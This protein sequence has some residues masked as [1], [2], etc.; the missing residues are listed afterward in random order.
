MLQYQYGSV[1]AQAKPACW[2]RSYE[3]GNRECR[4]C[5]FQGS[6]K[7]E[8]IRAAVNRPQMYQPP[9]YPQYQQ[10]QPPI[11]VPQVQVPQYQPPQPTFARSLTNWQPQPQPQPQVMQQGLA[12][13]A[14]NPAQAIPY[15]YGWL[16]D[17]M[18]YYIHTT[19]PPQRPQLPGETFMG[20]VVKN[21]GLAMMESFFASMFLAVR[22]M[23]WAPEPEYIDVVPVPQQQ[24][25]PIP[26]PPPRT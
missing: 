15:G 11:P 24:P 19:P 18:H 12:R 20:R 4:N 7:D 10:Y 25:V 17:P 6:C 13:T 16:N 3:E 26:P 2:G 5:G 21:A 8:I 1:N 9:Q 14:I 22:Q 23:T